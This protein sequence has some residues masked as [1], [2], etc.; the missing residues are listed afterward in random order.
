M[1]ELLEFFLDIIGWILSSSGSPTENH[2]SDPLK[3]IIIVVLVVLVIV[4]G[5]I[6]LFS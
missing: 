6:V 5:F 4:I 2:S 1:G 3:L